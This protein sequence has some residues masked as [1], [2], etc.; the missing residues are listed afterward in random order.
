MGKWRRD[1]HEA[2]KLV[3]GSVVLSSLHGPSIGSIQL[4]QCRG[5][6]N[7]ASRFFH[8]SLV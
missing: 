3:A 1:M 8:P 5:Q 6:C 4:A 2:R 7:A